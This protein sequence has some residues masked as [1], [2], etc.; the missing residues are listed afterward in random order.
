MCACAHMSVCACVCVCISLY[1]CVSC[2]DGTLAAPLPLL[3][4]ST[5]FCPPGQ[6][7]RVL[8][9]FPISDAQTK[10]WDWARPRPNFQPHEG[11]TKPPPN[12]HQYSTNTS[13]RKYW[14]SIGGVLVGSWWGPRGAGHLV[15]GLPAGLKFLSMARNL[16]LE[17]QKFEKKPKAWKTGPW[18]GKLTWGAKSRGAAEKRQRGR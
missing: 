7:S 18:S 2:R 9:L 1:A 10:F 13:R 5:E 17:R 6:V 8:R 16:G 12:P 4:R 14:W 15:A 11:P 3:R